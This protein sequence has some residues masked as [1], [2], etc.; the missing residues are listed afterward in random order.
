M[1]L[2]SEGAEVRGGGLP[3]SSA[4]PLILRLSQLLQRFFQFGE[5]A[6]G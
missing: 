5:L 6:F 4:R 2:S 1:P 3:Q